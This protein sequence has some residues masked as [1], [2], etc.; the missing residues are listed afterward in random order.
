MNIKKYEAFIRAVELGS[1]SKAAEELGYTQSGISHMMQSLEEEVGFPLLVRTPSGI[2]PNAEGEMLLPAIRRLLSTNDALAQ[3]IAKIK[4]ADTG[5]VRVIAF[6][7]VAAYWLPAIAGRFQKDYPQVEVMIRE[8]DEDTVAGAMEAHEVDLCIDA[9]GTA[10][11]LEWTPLCRDRL[12]AVFPQG[13][14][15]AGEPVVTLE[16]LRGERLLLPQ[17]GYGCEARP[18]LERLPEE[19][20]VRFITCSEYVALSMVTAGLGVSVLPELLLRHYQAGTVS[21]P[22][23]PAQYRTLGMGVPRRAAASPAVQ[24]FMGYVR[25]YV[26]NTGQNCTVPAPAAGT[27]ER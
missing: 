13:H 14:R 26:G 16:M 1:L 15:L 20:R 8:G 5:K 12:M 18:V 23:E 6:P 10:R 3:T 9:G 17:K 11:T 4:G 7:S 19:S 27:R 24:N 2:V 21:V 22:L 25:A